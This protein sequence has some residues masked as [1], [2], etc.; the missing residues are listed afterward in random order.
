MV[1]FELIVGTLPGSVTVVE[2]SL[3]CMTVAESLP[4]LVTV[5]GASLGRE[6]NLAYKDIKEVKKCYKG[7]AYLDDD[8]DDDDDELDLC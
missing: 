6:R 7:W 4:A 8:D 5:L 3:V 2:A 1:V